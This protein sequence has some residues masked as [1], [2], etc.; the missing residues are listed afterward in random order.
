MCHHVK[1]DSKSILHITKVILKSEI[2]ERTTEIG[3]AER[4]SCMHRCD[5][6]GLNWPLCPMF[7]LT[8]PMWAMLAYFNIWTEWLASKPTMS[9]R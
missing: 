8:M 4:D 9:D 3:V 1:V 7:S 5:G 2:Y 6:K